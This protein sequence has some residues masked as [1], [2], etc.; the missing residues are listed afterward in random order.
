MKE[1]NCEICGGKDI[2]IV[3]D[4][5]IR[6]GAPG[7]LTPIK[8]K[9]YQCNC[10]KTIWHEHSK[11]ENDEYY[12]SKE[13]RNRL[14]GTTELEKYYSMH[15]FEVLDKFNYCGTTIFRN[16]TV[17][18]IG[19]GG[20]GFLDF[21]KGVA[22]E[23]IAI[24][25]SAEYQKT[26]KERGYYTYT[27]ASNAIKEWGG[28]VD[29]VTSFD[30]IEHVDNTVEFMKDVFNLLSEG[31][32]AIIGTPTDCPLMRELLG[33]V[34]EQGLL[35]SYQHNW[36]LSEDGFKLCCQKAGFSKIKIK[37]VQR[38]G[39]SN[40][41][42]W[43]K[44]K[45]PSGHTHFEFVTDVLDKTYKSELEKSGLADYIIAYVEK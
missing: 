27:Y 9:M 35:Y 29:V 2:S 6:D 32:R 19:C 25:P 24:E 34:Y 44:N 42:E 4:D 31:G 14:E 8:Y 30:V 22:K 40:M 11:S 43:I 5:Y 37:Y 13:Y 3:Y 18:D 41:I 10:C 39:I 16:A 36:I 15:D 7:T 28:N 20:G 1:V 26:L 38:Y 33:H 17:A 45:K 12:T 21:L 23:I